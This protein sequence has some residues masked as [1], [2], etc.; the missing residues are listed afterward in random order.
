MPVYNRSWLDWVS[1]DDSAMELGAPA[2]AKS[3][4]LA[5]LRRAALPHALPLRSS[6][7]PGSQVDR[8]TLLAQMPVNNGSGTDR[9]SREDRSLELVAPAEPRHRRMLRQRVAAVSYSMSPPLRRCRCMM[10][11]GRSG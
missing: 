9:V 8:V 10:V 5:G 7:Q 6:E 11:R 3:A 4:Q 1:R 2:A